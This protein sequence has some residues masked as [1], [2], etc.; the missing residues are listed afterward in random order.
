MLGDLGMPR[1]AD[2]GEAAPGLRFVGYVYRPGL[3][4]YVGRLG[5]TAARGI[6]QDRGRVAVPA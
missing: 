2:G 5:R 3:T 6:A 1:V 4:G